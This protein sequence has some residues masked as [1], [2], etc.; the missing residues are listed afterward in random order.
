VLSFQERIE[1]V[2]NTRNPTKR[3][4]EMEELTGISAKTWTNISYRKQKAN[5]E[6]LEALFKAFPQYAFWLATGQTR[7]DVGDTSPILERIQADLRKA[8]R[9]AA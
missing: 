9:D 7:E 3:F 8:G 4:R 1:E 5:Q 2:I 6:H